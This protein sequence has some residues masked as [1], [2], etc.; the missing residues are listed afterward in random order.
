VLTHELLAFADLTVASTPW[1]TEMPVFRA[2]PG[3]TAMIRPAG[4]WGRVRGVRP[5]PHERFNVGYIGTVDFAKMHPR[6][7]SMSARIRV[8]E[9]RFVVCG[10]GNA[11]ATL[12]RQAAQLEMSDRFELRGYVEDVRSVIAQLDVFGY[13]L[14]EHNYSASELVLQEVM[15]AGV[16]P[17]VLANG[18][19]QRSVL[20]GRTGLV[21]HDEDGYVRAIERLHAEPGE[22]RRLGRGAREHASRAWGLDDAADRW[23]EAYELLLARPKRDRSWPAAPRSPTARL[24]PAAARFV[25]SLGDTAPAFTISMEDSDEQ[26]RQ[27][28]EETIATAAPALASADSGGV[29]HWRRRYPQDPLLRLWAGLVLHGQGRPALAAGEFNAALRLGLAHPHASSYLARSIADA[30]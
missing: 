28:A 9:A 1:T 30:A 2:A 12:A 8:P 5:Q 14:C 4:G 23:A 27:A 3:P 29:L 24:A 6:Y 18:G 13:P 17:V 20:N 26:R 15:Y 21:V 10:S 25:Q 22:R 19:A 16:P 7:V 11:F